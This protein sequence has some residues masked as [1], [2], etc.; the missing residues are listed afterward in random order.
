[1]KSI[2]KEIAVIVFFLL[3]IGLTACNGAPVT[4]PVVPLATV[5]PVAQAQ[6]QAPVGNNEDVDEEV[7]IKE[8]VEIKYI[9]WDANQFPAYEACAANFTELNPSIQVNVEQ[10]GWGDYWSTLNSQLDAGNAPDVFANHLSK[11]PEYSAKNQILDIQPFVDSDELDVGIYLGELEKLWVRDGARFGLPKDWDTVAVVYDPAVLADAG[12][13]SEE[14]NNATWNPEDGG[15][16]GEI[17]KK[18][19]LDENGNDGLSPD[20][21]KTKVVRYG[22]AAD[23]NGT[24]AYGQTVFSMFAASTGWNFV[25]GLY[26]T[27]YYY[28]DQRFIDTMQWFQDMI[29]DGYFAPYDEVVSFSSSVLFADGKSALTTDGSW[30]IG[31][32]SGLEDIESGFARLP[33]GPNGR[34]SMF[35]GLAD[36]V[37]TGTA[38]PEAAWEWVKYAASSDCAQLVGNYGVVFPA[39]QSGVWNAIDVY[40]SRGV[41]VTAF[42]SQVE[43]GGT[44]LF[45]ITDNAS[46][47]DAIMS[48]AFAQIYRGEA[49]AQDILIDANER[50]NATFN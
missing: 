19:T 34:K 16:F 43:E 29:S 2:N 38:H 44:F 26:A 50:V 49:P 45:P 28:D 1:M 18:L 27:E 41:D 4:E 6:E 17:V 36:S 5:T 11:Y 15:Q 23:Y 9:V 7:V 8:D 13:T 3:L 31:Y 40:T 35:N 47:I 33:I 48:E 42:T 14:L 46:D 24:G 37:W 30:M 20:F 39:I 22:Y 21:D 12:I 10:I 25:D 32:Y